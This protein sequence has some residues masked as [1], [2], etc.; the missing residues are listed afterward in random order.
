MARSRNIK[1]GYFESDEL[2]DCGIESHFVFAGLWC[3]ADK[4]G[5]LRDR[6]K[7]IKAAVAPYYDFDVDDSLERLEN[8]G[9]IDRYEID[10]ERYIQVRNW[11][12]HQKPHHKE[13]PSEI[14]CLGQAK[15]KHDSRLSQD[16]F[17]LEPSKSSFDALIPD[18]GYLIPDCGFL[19]PDTLQGPRGRVH[20]TLE[21]A[22]WRC[23]EPR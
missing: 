23:Q 5:R 16:R 12:K 10:G 9:F 2:A 1:P 7:R 21:C 19:I 6:P 20:Q 18:S 8:A 13:A 3:I 4:A 22:N 17:N 15:A 11:G 14:P